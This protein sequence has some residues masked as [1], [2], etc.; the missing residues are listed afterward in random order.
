MSDDV[1]D[2]YI[3]RC[4]GDDL[5]A[6][7]NDM[8]GA[9]L[10]RASCPR[11]WILRNK[12]QPGQQASVPDPVGYYIWRDTCWT[13]RTPCSGSLVPNGVKINGSTKAMSTNAPVNPGPYPPTGNFFGMTVDQ[14]GKRFTVSTHMQTRH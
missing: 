11:G 9:N 5:F 10:P 7:S 2:A 13:Q 8:T 3:F 1:L 4:A 12:S 14:R 6:V